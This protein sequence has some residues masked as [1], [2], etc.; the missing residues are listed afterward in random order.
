MHAQHTGTHAH[1]H[2]QASPWHW[3]TPH[4]GQR[5]LLTLGHGV[6]GRAHRDMARK[7]APRPP[8]TRETSSLLG[9]VQKPGGPA[10]PGAGGLRSPG[11]PGECA[12]RWYGPAPY[13]PLLQVGLLVFSSRTCSLGRRR[14]R[15]HAGRPVLEPASSRTVSCSL[16][17]LEGARGWSGGQS[18][19]PGNPP[20]SGPAGP[21]AQAP[22]RYEQ[23]GGGRGR[24]SLL[25]S[26]RNSHSLPHQQPLQP[27]P[28]PA[29]P[30]RP[31][32]SHW[33]GWGLV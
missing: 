21:H 20:H 27:E 6:P 3:E 14:P 28:P 8:R 33:P 13:P 15:A 1:T 4:P 11:R 9:Q 10:R 25:P 26:L 2:T 29:T 16:R 24:C 23:G 31:S 30:P 7:S 5:W 18:P 12:G 17:R 22:L 19:L 32:P